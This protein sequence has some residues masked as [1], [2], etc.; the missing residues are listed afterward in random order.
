M[1]ILGIKKDEKKILVIGCWLKA[2]GLKLCENQR[3][4]S[5]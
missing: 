3:E 2:Q 1:K 5:S 4:K